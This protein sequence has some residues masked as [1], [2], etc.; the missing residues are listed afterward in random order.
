VNAGAWRRA[1]AARG[2]GMVEAAGFGLCG[3]VG[4]RWS[5]AVWTG[6][7]ARA[8]FSKWNRGWPAGAPRE[9]RGIWRGGR[10]ADSRAGGDEEVRGGAEAGSGTAWITGWISTA[11]ANGLL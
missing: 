2:G 9:R 5:G 3:A 7:W 8:V 4:A 6:G 1:A 11:F 10:R